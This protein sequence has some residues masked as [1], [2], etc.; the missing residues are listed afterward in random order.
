MKSWMLLAGMLL[1]GGADAATLGITCTAP[2]QTDKDRTCTSPILAPM[3]AN[4]DL[5]IHFQWSGPTPGEDSVSTVPGRRLYLFRTVLPGVYSVRCWAS[6]H[7][8]AGCDTLMNIPVLE[9]R[10]PPARVR[11]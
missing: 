2:D 6:D 3:N 11:P 1:A 8:V 4:P 9:G 7:N 10:Y 5:K